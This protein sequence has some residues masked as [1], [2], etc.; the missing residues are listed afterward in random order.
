MSSE[1][2]SPLKPTQ[3]S[4]LSP[5]SRY[6]R[7]KQQ[8]FKELQKAAY[9]CLTKFKYEIDEN[10]KLRAV[11]TKVVMI[12]EKITSSYS[13]KQQTNSTENYVV[14]VAADLSVEEIPCN[15]EEEKADSEEREKKHDAIVKELNASMDKYESIKRLETSSE[16]NKNDKGKE[17]AIVITDELERSGLETLKKVMQGYNAFNNDQS[18]ALDC[19]R[20]L[21][22]SMTNEEQAKTDVEE[23]KPLPSPT[24][25]SSPSPTSTT[26][27]ERKIEPVT[28]ENSSKWPAVWKI[29]S[30]AAVAFLILLRLYLAL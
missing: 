5:T 13:G 8:Q 28:K 29:L 30:I 25:S 9:N 17:A 24:A 3:E 23:E 21:S 1:V 7:E 2:L 19:S 18:N 11:A 6:K 12:L 4:F 22:R 15:E 16:G 10:E 26:L 14:T 20:V 27:S